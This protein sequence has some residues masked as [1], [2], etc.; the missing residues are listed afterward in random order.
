M[1]TKVEEAFKVLDEQHDDYLQA[2]EYRGEGCWFGHNFAADYAKEYAA[3]RATLAAHIA[4][5][6]AV[7][8]DNKRLLGLLERVQTHLA[9]GCVP[10]RGYN[11]AH[12]NLSIEID[13]ALK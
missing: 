1:N 11:T 12:K 6:D 2:G 9:V 5:Q 10:Q 3:A 13:E 8:E 4:Q 7:M